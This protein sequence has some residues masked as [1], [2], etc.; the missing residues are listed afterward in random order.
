MTKNN[1]F[2]IYI[3]IYQ[4]LHPALRVPQAETMLTVYRLLAIRMPFQL[5]GHRDGKGRKHFFY[6][7]LS[8]LKIRKGVLQYRIFPLGY[9]QKQT[10]SSYQI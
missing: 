1:I 6:F 5:V 4:R 10:F 9:G 8:F 2:Y 3:R 7:F